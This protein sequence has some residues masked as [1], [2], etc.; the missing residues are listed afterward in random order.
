V[1]DLLGE[2]LVELVWKNEA[3]AR[4]PGRR[5]TSTSSNESSPQSSRTC[6]GSPTSPSTGLAR[7][8][9]YLCAVKDVCGNRIVGYSIDSRMRSRIAVNAFNNAVAMRQAAGYDVADCIA[10]SDRGSQFRSRKAQPALKRHSLVGSMG[11]V[12]AA[13]DNAAMESF[14]SL[15]QNNVLNKKPSAAREELRIAIVTWI[16][17]THHRRPRQDA[18]GELT[19]SST[20][21]S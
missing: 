15:L 1:E 14:F 16:E 5:F 13:G 18:L 4:S 17:K 2:R 8:E 10:R 21:P 9:L 7:A 3:R 11:R 19:P 20:R 12:S 6:C